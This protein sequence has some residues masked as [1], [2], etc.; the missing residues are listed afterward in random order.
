MG[1][2]GRMNPPGAPLTNPLLIGSIGATL[3]RLSLPNMLAMLAT[4]LVA[5]AETGYVGML[6]TE[7]L[8]GMALVFPLVMLQQMLSAGSM[9]GGI[10]AA[11]SRALGANDALRAQSLARHAACI[12]LVA[13]L[14]FTL[15]FLIF[16]SA[17]YRALGGT[18]LAL[19]EALVYS[20]VVFLG[21]ISIWMT[22]ALASVV[23]GCGNMKFPSQVLLGV[24]ALQVV[25]GG[26]LGLGI[27][28]LP[29]WGMT[30][31]ALGQ[32]IAYTWGMWMFMRFL[33]KPLSRVPLV[34]NLQFNQSDFYDILK[35]GA[36]SSISS[37]QT[38]LT[39]LI[40]T[41]IVS[42]FGTEALA[43]YGIGSR[44]E[45]LLI[46][47]TFA[48]GVACVP[49]V[50][51]ALGAGMVQRARRVAWTGA[52]FSAVSVGLIG[53]LVAL[54]PNL[55]SRLFSD[56]AQVLAY[57]DTYFAW[58]G[59]CYAF[60]GFGLCLYFASQGAGKLWGPV[61]AGTLRLVLVGAGGTWLMLTAAPA[62]QM[63]ALI[64][65]A[66]VLYGLAT[67]LSVYWVSWA[68]QKISART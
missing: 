13:G 3:W 37:I 19:S 17:I 1:D 10:S 4:A 7:Q 6:G 40:I 8:A 21:A 41:R 5:V 66:M 45:F 18:G 27:G 47:I 46:P 50:G 15:L 53:L 57:A 23:R 67:G 31:V 34:L 65:G 62:W 59:P 36:V 60:F 20:N 58:V 68:P 35:V 24:A 11:I 63:F 48:F 51:M 32:V 14:L 33:R 38:V 49:M 16:G 12:A 55:W 9:G 44:L 30:G 54:A 25:L 2:N 22:N 42:H 52:A 28:P 39:I 26:G 64:G 43:G 56:Q 29:H 61:L